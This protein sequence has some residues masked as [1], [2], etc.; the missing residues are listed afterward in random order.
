MKLYLFSLPVFFAAIAVEAVYYHYLLKRPYGWTTTGSNLVVAIGRLISDGL[1]KGFVVAVY[2]AAYE[3]RPFD[4]AMDSWES[5]VALFFAIELAYYWLHRLSHEI[6]WMWAQHSVHHSAQQMTLSV[7]YRLGWTQ[8]IAGPWLF[9]VPVCWIGFDPRSVGLMY[10]ANLLYQFWLHTEM[11]GKLGWLEVIFNTPSHHR[12]H[13]ATEAEYLDRNYGGVLILWDKLFGT[14]AGER[15][16]A[17]RTYGLVRQID[18]NNP[19]KIAFA[20]W[21]ALL[22]DLNGAKTWNERLHYLFGAPGWRPHGDGLTTKAI[23]QAGGV[24][25]DAHGVLD[26]S[27]VQPADSLRRSAT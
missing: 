4:I 3:L 13:H 23:R 9:L 14:F 7:A 10:A 26:L 21:A 11:V 8:F 17:P 27:E 6:R 24:P 2:V 16:G 18:T 15:D 22:R 12:V 20:E 25:Q 19:A 5:W 1:S